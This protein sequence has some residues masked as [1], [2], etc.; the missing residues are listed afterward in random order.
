[1]NYVMKSVNEPDIVQYQVVEKVNNLIVIKDILSN[2][3][4]HVHNFS[5]TEEAST[6]LLKVQKVNLFHFTV[7]TPFGSEQSIV[8]DQYR[9]FTIDG[10]EEASEAFRK[11]VSQFIHE[12]HRKVHEIKAELAKTQKKIY[13]QEVRLKTDGVGDLTR[14][15]RG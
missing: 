8:V 10:S 13:T 11:S 14:Y 5:K 2:H 7:A 3:I 15:W 4:F 1:M 9:V 6:F 12:A